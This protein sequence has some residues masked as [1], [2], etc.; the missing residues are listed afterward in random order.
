MVGICYGLGRDSGGVALLNHRL[1][2]DTPAGVRFVL[3][4]FPVVC[5]RHAQV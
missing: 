5:K 4:W 1:Q 3:G 2:A